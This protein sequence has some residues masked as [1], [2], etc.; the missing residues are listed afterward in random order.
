MSSDQIA[1][2]RRAEDLVECELLLREGEPRGREC[3]RE[4]DEQRASGCHQSKMARS[5]V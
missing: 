1:G 5:P 2:E 4:S 3:D